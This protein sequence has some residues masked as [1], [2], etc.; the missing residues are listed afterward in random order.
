MVKPVPKVLLWRKNGKTQTLTR[1]LENQVRQEMSAR[2]KSTEA[3]LKALPVDRSRRK[4]Q[5]QANLLIA[6][7]LQARIAVFFEEGCPETGELHRRCQCGD[8][9]PH[10]IDCEVFALDE[11]MRMALARVL[12][13]G[14]R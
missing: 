6:E 12:R 3:F 11:G 13:K 14:N 9:S 4:I 8:Y 5:R 2:L 10:C 7:E 1:C